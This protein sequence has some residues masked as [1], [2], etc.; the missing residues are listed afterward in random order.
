MGLASM[1]SGGTAM[2][3]GYTWLNEAV[4]GKKDAKLRIGPGESDLLSIRFDGEADED[5]QAFRVVFTSGDPLTLDPLIVG[6]IPAEIAFNTP[7]ARIF[8]DALPIRRGRKWFKHWATLRWPDKLN[9]VERRGESRQHVP[10]DIDIVAVLSLPEGGPTLRARLWD[11]DVTGAA[12]ICP[13]HAELP[14]PVVG[15]PVGILLNHAGLEYRLRGFCRN[16]QRLSSNSLR[17]G[18]QFLSE[19]EV[20]AET[21][22]RF[23]QLLEDLR[24][25]TI[26]RSF[27]KDLRKTVTYTEE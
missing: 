9:V 3:S 26:R 4:W 13:A 14:T 5:G 27:R 16:V 10:D 15:D 22:V 12:C 18:L 19:S 17:V 11:V 23:K 21:L 7:S 6:T 20:D 24:T 2:I 25:T 8:F 1:S